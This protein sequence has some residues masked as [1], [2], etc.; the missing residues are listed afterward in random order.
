MVTNNR[1]RGTKGGDAATT[2]AEIQAAGGEAFPCF[3]SVSDYGESKKLIQTAVDHYGKI[4][5]LVNNAA[6]LLNGPLIN[7]T[8]KQMR[9]IVDINILGVLFA[10]SMLSHT[11]PNKSTERL[12]TYLPARPSRVML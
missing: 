10:A 3:G 7:Y 5:V 11:W 9:D 1:K 2:A 12:S 4:D 8:E 6:I